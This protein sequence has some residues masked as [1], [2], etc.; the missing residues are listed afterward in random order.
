MKARECSTTGP[1]RW[2]PTCAQRAFRIAG[3]GAD[4]SP[5]ARL[6]VAKACS[7]VLNLLALPALYVFARRRYGCRVAIW[8][9][10]VLAVLPVHAIYAGFH[11]S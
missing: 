4:S 5:Q 2:M 1:R 10:A 9:M 7:F 8:T 6:V 3:L 11:A